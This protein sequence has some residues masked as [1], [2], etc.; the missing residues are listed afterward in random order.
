MDIKI[1][2]CHNVYN[3]GASLQAYALSY[4]LKT[5][6]HNVEIINYQ[7]G[8]QR[9]LFSL[10][11]I[12]NPKYN[13]PIL[14]QLYIFAKLWGRINGLKS[15]KA[16]DKFT[17]TYLPLT[18]EYAS[19][20]DLY[21]H[22]PK[23]DLFIAGSDQIWN[24]YFPNGRDKAFYL[25]FGEC[26]TRKISYAPSFA[27]DTISPDLHDFVQSNIKS[28]DAV[29]VREKSAL[30][31]LNSLDIKSAIQVCDPVFLLDK[32][33]WM[34]LAQLSE[35]NLS[36]YILVY[37]CSD[38]FKVKDSA[39]RLRD[40][41]GNKIVYLGSWEYADINIPHASPIDFLNAINNSN[42]VITDSY[43]ATL[44]SIL[45]EK[46]FFVADRT[47]PLNSRIHDILNLMSLTNRIISTPD[48]I[49]VSGI[50]FHNHFDSINQLITDSKDYLNRQ[51]ELC[52]KAN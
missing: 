11:A 15:K 34:H 4:Y 31:I 2:T 26:K 24:T 51:I 35:L 10:K 3:F 6:G 12:N 9:S 48:S 43:H 14:R 44:F 19:Y 21:H 42:F 46:Q 45:F 7:P 49:S 30:R 28:L 5:L 47:E 23:A 8:Y 13:K 1:I 39:K 37:E 41:T 50:N 38:N 17:S 27:I 25:R 33:H 40:V 32:S 20:D 29:S 52:K 36:N 16:F 18:R 22:P